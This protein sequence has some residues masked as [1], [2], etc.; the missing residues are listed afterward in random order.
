VVEERLIDDHPRPLLNQEGSKTPE[1]L[2]DNLI[3]GCFE[4]M[5]V[6]QSSRT[7]NVLVI[8]RISDVA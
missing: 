7:Q 5:K 1:F 6:L 3:C 8:S 4:L 2:F